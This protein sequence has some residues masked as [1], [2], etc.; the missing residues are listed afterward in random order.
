M[1]QQQEAVTEFFEFIYEEEEGYVYV[2]LK[3]INDNVGF[4]QHF[5][6]WPKD[7][8]RITDFVLENASSYEV[9]YG[10]ALYSEPVA[11]KDFVKVSR[12]V[13]CE[14]DGTVPDQVPSG[15]PEPSLR[16][17]SS[18]ADHQHWYWKLD[19]GVAPD[20][21]ERINRSLTYQ[22]GA[23]SSGWDATQILRPVLTTNHKRQAEVRPVALTQT[24]HSIPAFASIPEPPPRVEAPIPDAIPPVDYVIAKYQFSLKV[25][26]LFREG[27]AEGKRSEG[28][29]S[30]AY[31]LAE[32]G[33]QNAEMLAILLNADSRWGKFS[34]R[35]DQMQRLMDLIQRAKSKHPVK[36][37]EATEEKFKPY[38]LF[39][40]LAHK[41]ELEWVWD[42]LLAKQGSMLLT[43]PPG[44]GKTQ[45]SL[46]A[47][48]HFA[49]GKD[50][51]G[52]SVGEPQTVAFFSL[53]MSLPEFKYFLAKIKDGY[54]EPERR[55][56]D[57]RVK[58]FP[59]GEPLYLSQ[60]K[61]RQRVAEV[62][63][64]CKAEG[65]FFDSLGSTTEQSVSNEEVAKTLMDYVDQLRNRLGV[66]TWF[67]HHHRKANSD[68]KK[69][70]KLSDVY[71]NQYLTA[72]PSTVLCLWPTGVPN[73]LEGIPL[74]VRLSETPPSF[75]IYRGQYLDFRSGA[76]KLI[77]EAEE[78]ALTD[79]F[80]KTPGDGLESI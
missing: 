36:K 58:L 3:A 47:M 71:G 27:V 68:N 44:V 73:T 29:M 5:F 62:V 80:D 17:Q 74:K 14:F 57:E 53:E 65:V 32:M 45:L 9:Y 13:W 38:S 16:V 7:K 52:R 70:N 35:S 39:E 61:E 23:D 60:P 75:P 18:E 76:P 48:C 31:S 79:S 4:K 40:L 34:Q 21:L 20:I 10:P 22:L 43:G 19:S 28:L 24:V 72:R 8:D 50:F 69:P 33:M 6:E 11:R 15:I 41:V 63:R 77:T 46:G 37:D 30:L 55:Q 42:G 25:F 54:T 78:E 66:F 51:L 26:R 2:A 1:P 12:V 49:L 64:D 67:I 56:I 59:I